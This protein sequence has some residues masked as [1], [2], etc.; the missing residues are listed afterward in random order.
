MP[1]TSEPAP[2]PHLAGGHEDPAVPALEAGRFSGPGEFAQRI[3]DALAQAAAQQWGVMV[4][5]DADFRDWPLC[6][7]QVVE[8][9]QAW[10]RKG[11]KLR[12]M[13]RRFD[14][15]PQWHPR[16]VAWRRQWDHII[17]CQLCAPIAGLE[18]PSAL[19]TP[20]YAVLRLDTERSVGW[21]GVERARLT[22]IRAE[23]DECAKHSTP[24]FPAT[25]LGL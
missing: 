24:G 6:E 11:R 21:S 18:L 8:A 17:E 16:F 19:W 4:W 15:F 20:D 14:G 22:Q 25:T 13:A 5:A 10:S 2:A 7:R 3:R 1:D 23:L 9:M 12:L